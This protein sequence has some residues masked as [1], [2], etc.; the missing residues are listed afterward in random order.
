MKEI[1]IS[2]PY[3]E[4]KIEALRHFTDAEKP[5]LEEEITATI[6]RLYVR[7]VPA[8]VR[9]FIAAQAKSS[10]PDGE[11]RRKKKPEPARQAPESTRQTAEPERQT[12]E[13]TRQTAESTRQTAE[14][15][16]QT[17]ESA[18]KSGDP[19]DG[20]SKGVRASV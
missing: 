16:R 3:A 19:G 8:P 4:A 20:P 10:S 9:D 15:E 2:V 17:S 11:T 18:P 14:S 7:N 12:A 6:D 1:T 5:S 13:S